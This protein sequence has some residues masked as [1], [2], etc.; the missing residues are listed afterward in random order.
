VAVREERRS[1][2]V[3]LP[4]VAQTL[5]SLG[6]RMAARGSRFLRPICDGRY[7]KVVGP[8]ATHHGDGLRGREAETEVA[9]PAHV[10]T[11]DLPLPAAGLGRLGGRVPQAL[12][13]SYE[14]AQAAAVWAGIPSQEELFG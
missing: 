9:R 6:G 8:D 14:S 7:A 12:V 11:F 3:A 10:A 4:R 13:E 1:P 5:G 2:G